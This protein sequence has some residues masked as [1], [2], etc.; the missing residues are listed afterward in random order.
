M[1]TLKI[2]AMAIVLD[3]PMAK[4]ESW[5]SVFPV[6]VMATF[7]PRYLPFFAIRKRNVTGWLESYIPKGLPRNR[8]E[9]SLSRFTASTIPSQASA[10]WS[11]AFAPR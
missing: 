11:I 3:M 8:S 9:M 6:T 4:G 7:I 1:K 2:R 10:G 5:N